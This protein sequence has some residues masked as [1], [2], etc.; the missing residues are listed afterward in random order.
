[1][2]WKVIMS[3]RDTILPYFES[4]VWDCNRHENFIWGI[5]WSLHFKRTL[6]LSHAFLLCVSKRFFSGYAGIWMK[7]RQ[8]DCFLCPVLHLH[9]FS[10]SR[11]I[12]ARMNRWHRRRDTITKR[13][14]GVYCTG[15]RAGCFVPVGMATTFLIISFILPTIFIWTVASE[16]TMLCWIER[17][18]NSTCWCLLSAGCLVTF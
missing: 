16:V 8:S 10:T 18:W 6:W 17:C 5:F 11:H 2:L 14:S 4:N 3:S 1:M 12:C 9:L 13:Y 7:W 15:N